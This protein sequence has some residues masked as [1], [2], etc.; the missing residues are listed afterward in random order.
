MKA[1]RVAGAL[2]WV[3]VAALAV[4]V[5]PTSSALPT[6]RHRLPSR[7]SPPT[8]PDTL[9]R[10]I[11]SALSLYRAAPDSGDVA[12]LL[13]RW[14]QIG[15]PASAADSLAASM[16]W[17]R[18][19]RSG[20]AIG[21]LPG[22]APDGPSA[23]RVELERARILFA[24]GTSPAA[25]PTAFW[26]A[27][28]GMDGETKRE[29]WLDL[30]SLATPAE[31]AEWGELAPGG[32]ACSWLRRFVAER[33][34]RMAVPPD[35]RVALHYRRLA[36]ARERYWLRRPRFT[37]DLTDWLG[38][39]DSLE[40]DDRGLVY[41]RMGRPE[42]TVG[43]GAADLE[44][45]ESWAYYRP[46]GARI[47]HFAA[48][49]R[50]YGGGFQPVGDYRLLENLAHATGLTMTSELMA[51]GGARIA[52]LYG[53]R[54]L[55]DLGF[56]RTAFRYGEADR[57]MRA[58]GRPF[59]PGFLGVLMKERQQTKEDA[60]YVV[61][62]V[63]DVPQVEPRVRFAYETLRFEE[64][65]GERAEVWVVVSARAGD[66]TDG[67]VA[68][69]H[70]YGVGARVAL[71][72][73][74]GYREARQVSSLIRP[75]PVSDDDG[76]PVRISLELPPGRYP[77]TVAIRDEHAGEPAVGNW[78]H[79]TLIVGVGGF[80][81]RLSDIA[82]AQDSGGSW[83]RDGAVFLKPVPNHVVGGD[84][85]LHLYFE[86][87]GLRPR[88]AYEVD[89][90]L[91]PREA[92]GRIFQLDAEEVAFGLRYLSEMPAGAAPGRQHLRL[93]LADTEPGDYLLAVRATDLEAG[94]ASLPALTTVT[95]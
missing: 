61:Q 26:L 65:G 4:S 18:A 53:S 3:A 80:L 74:E 52:A 93:N 41:V 46:Q 19:G 36:R 42:G 81:P 39:P 77:L 12:K 68:G 20:L 33:A 72:T 21:A 71:L 60:R 55:L 23:A 56:R 89:L 40:F 28:D 54:G 25:A 91:V 88:S 8:L 90:R 29:L 78:A 70:R 62:T 15:G 2:A 48:V 16:L 14:A 87:Y 57:R 50:A 5:A 38:R 67:G 59:D 63:P 1:A 44:T 45:N 10:F 11:R 94:A 79:D 95:R 92:G 34:W 69:T 49:S 58:A 32:P 84:G 17:R 83:T 9:P 66:L 6:S 76:V 47:Y 51:V 30:R 64:P 7:A 73:P 24:A 35:E 13:A 22:P 37:R 31:Q 82:V 86:L 85:T 43:A 27:C 75:R